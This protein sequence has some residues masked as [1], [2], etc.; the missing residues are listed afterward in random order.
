MKC[1][2]ESSVE[3][4]GDEGMVGG[5]V[6]GELSDDMP[7][8]IE[9]EN[10]T[11]TVKGYNPYTSTLRPISP[12]LSAIFE[13]CKPWKFKCMCIHMKIRQDKNLDKIKSIEFDR[14][15]THGRYLGGD[16]HTVFHK[17]QS[18]ECTI[19]VPKSHYQPGNHHAGH[20]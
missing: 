17:N 13:Y 16:I 8:L 9:S 19:T 2:G 14:Y 10:I 6:I 11:H 20:F 5:R 3:G 4:G 15:W 7:L 1:V 12:L 18:A